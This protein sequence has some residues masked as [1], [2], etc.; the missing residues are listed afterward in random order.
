[1]SGGVVEQRTT[2]CEEVWHAQ[3][4]AILGTL[5]PACSCAQTWVQINLSEEMTAV[6][7]L[8][9]GAWDERR[10]RTFSTAN[11]VADALA[12]VSQ[13]SDAEAV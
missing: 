11:P 13:L 1:M 10:P 12:R 6:P 9:H 3:L 7:L 8:K 2:S 4:A 5:T